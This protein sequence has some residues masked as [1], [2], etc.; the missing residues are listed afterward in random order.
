MRGVSNHQDF[1]RFLSFFQDFKI[2]KDLEI[3]NIF[4]EFIAQIES[5]TF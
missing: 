3:S 4:K 1:Q 5:A 2:F